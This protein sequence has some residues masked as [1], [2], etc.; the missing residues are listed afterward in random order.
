MLGIEVPAQ[1][2]ADTHTLSVPS[3]TA[4]FSN[5][6]DDL[7]IDHAEDTD[8][9]ESDAIFLRRF[10]KSEETAWHQG[11]PRTDKLDEKFMNHAVAAISL[12]LDDVSSVVELPEVSDKDA[13]QM[14]AEE[15]DL[16]RQCSTLPLPPVQT[17]VTA[18]G[19]PFGLEPVSAGCRDLSF[20]VAER[21]K[22]QTEHERRSVRVGI[23]QATPSPEESLR[24][25]LVKGVNRLIREQEARG[26]STGRGRQL[27]WSEKSGPVP[28]ALVGNSANAAVA[29]SVTAKN[30]IKKRAKLFERAQVPVLAQPFLK[31]ARI[32]SLRAIKID[33]YGLVYHEK[34]G[35][36]LGKVIALYVKS[37]GKNARHGSVESSTTV[38]ALSNVAL[39]VSEFMYANSF[40]TVTAATAAFHTKHFVLVRPL[41]FLCALQYQPQEVNERVWT[42][43][44]ADL[45]LFNELNTSSSTKALAAAMKLSRK[46]G[47]D[48]VQVEDS[49]SGSDDGDANS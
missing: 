33:D 20:L 15:R 3:I 38:G 16:V 1:L 25:Q 27:R 42:L 14:Q 37:G 17:A 2:H 49:A 45:K 40:R 18:S 41:S 4:W 26:V 13:Q 5:G 12:A 28:S 46:R 47:K 19:R 7:A 9:E 31:E 36:M 30:A 21:L 32:S 10:L 22:H 44:T 23:E 11:T 34:H 43:Q 8:P 48:A 35:V 29:A 24:R 39:Q 6:L